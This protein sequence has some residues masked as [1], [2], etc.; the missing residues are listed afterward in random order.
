MA[1]SSAIRAAAA[2]FGLLLTTAIPPACADPVAT[3]DVVQIETGNSA[4]ITVRLAE[5]LAS[6]VDNEATRRI[7]PLV[8]QGGLRTVA[9]LVRMPGID[10]AILQLDVLDHARAQKLFPGLD[11]SITY[12]AKLNYVEFHLLARQQVRSIADLG[13]QT[14][15]IGPRGG[16]TAITATQLFGL[17]KL[18]SLFNDDDPDTAIVK[19]RRGE[20]GALAFVG[21]KPAPLLRLTSAQGLHLVPIPMTQ[22]VIATYVPTRLTATDYP[23]LVAPDAPVDTVAVGTGLF[24]G[25]LPPASD[26]YRKVADVVDIVFSQFQTLLAPGH[27]PKWSEV[28]LSSEIEG[29]RRFPPA[30]DWLKRHASITQRP[31]QRD[32]FMH[33]LNERDRAAGAPQMSQAQKDVLFE[34]FRQWQAVSGH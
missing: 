20:I 6:L 18:S 4:G 30:D 11:T 3:S 1:G 9:D 33:F 17:L 10:M 31:D 29:W 16:D 25:P 5:D 28:N 26:D 7:V 27:H 23:G 22:A 14:I 21:G 8:G 19:L 15:S 12:I 32:F 13:G 34:Q 2:A 24:V